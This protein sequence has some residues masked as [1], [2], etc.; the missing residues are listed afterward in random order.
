MV[1]TRA[2]K[3]QSLEVGN[4]MKNFGKKRYVGRI[5]IVMI[6]DVMMVGVTVKKN[7][8]Q[9]IRQWKLVLNPLQSRTD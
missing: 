9:K 1:G 8:W 2:E 7:D 5:Q 6:S 3:R 4:R